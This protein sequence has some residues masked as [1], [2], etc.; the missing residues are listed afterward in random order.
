MFE[1]TRK[2]LKQPYPLIQEKSRKWKAVFS[3]AALVA[4]FLFVFRPFGID[5]VHVSYPEIFIFGYGLV[6]MLVIMLSLFVMPVLIPSWFKEKAWTVGRNIIYTS[7]IVF[8]IGLGNLFY[9]HLF[10]GIELT[11]ISLINFQFFTLAVTFFIA[12]TSTFAR[13]HFLTEKNEKE[14]SE[15]SREMKRSSSEKTS[16]PKLS[17]RT[18]PIRSENGKEEIHVSTDSLLYIESADNYSEV[19]MEENDQIRKILV[20]STMKR[21]E[22]QLLDPAFF[23]CHRSYIVNLHKIDSVKGNSQGYQLELTNG[24]G[25]VLV[26]RKYAAELSARLKSLGATPL[27]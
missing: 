11:L 7:L 6:T 4:L 16:S 10:A 25:H 3:N 9:T 26:S 27:K 12:A 13:Y 1:R 8:F 5:A 22:D 2:S 24:S 19:V 17:N 23:R 21:I 15:I 18:Y 20:R 14:A